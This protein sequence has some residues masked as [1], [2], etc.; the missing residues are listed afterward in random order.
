MD[1]GHSVGG[2]SVGLWGNFLNGLIALHLSEQRH[3]G[4]GGTGGAGADYIG[5]LPL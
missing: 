2:L 1:A 5:H 3:L 4:M